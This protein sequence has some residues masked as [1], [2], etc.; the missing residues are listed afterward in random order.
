[1]GTRTHRSGL[2]SN[3]NGSGNAYKVGKGEGEGGRTWPRGGELAFELSTPRLAPLSAGRLVQLL[4]GLLDPD[5]REI[6]L[7]YPHRQF[8]SPRVRVVVDALLAHFAATPALHW[9][10]PGMG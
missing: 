9:R 7:H 4:P 6:H 8:L 1:M 5:A 10:P 2:A 3:G